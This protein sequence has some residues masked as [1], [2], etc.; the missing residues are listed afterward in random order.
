MAFRWQADNYPLFVVFEASLP[1]KKCYQSWTH[2]LLQ[3]CILNCCFANFFRSYFRLFTIY[4]R[5]LSGKNNNSLNMHF[6]VFFPKDERK[7]FRYIREKSVLSVY[8]VYRHP[9]PKITMPPWGRSGSVVECLTRDRG[10][11]GSSIIGVTAL[12]P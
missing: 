3:D 8:Y 5:H 6:S 10:A 11:R 1:S 4:S 12:C 9:W 2:G 7:I